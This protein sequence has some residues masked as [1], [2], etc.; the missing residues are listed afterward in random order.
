M[1]AKMREIAEL[2]GVSESTVSRALNNSPLI[3]EKTRK[4]ILEAAR[5]LHYRVSRVDMIGVIEP[6]ITNPLYAEVISAIETRIY[7]AGYGMLLCESEYELSRERDQLDFLLR[8]SSMQGIIMIPIDPQSEHIRQLISQNTPCVFLG[9]ETIPGADQVNVDASMGAY[10]VT[11]YLLELGHKRIGLLQGPNHVAVGRERL[12]G[13]CRALT[14]YQIAFDHKLVSEADIDEAGGALAMK[15]I[16]SDVGG[17]I[18]AVVAISDIMAVGALRYLRE[19]GFRIPEDISLVGCDDIPIG[20]FIQPALTTV[21]QPK[22]ELG[23]LAVKF[24]LKQIEMSQEREKE[25]K[26]IYPFQSTIYHPHI[27]IRESTRKKDE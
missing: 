11:R 9:S 3:S 12:K 25:W 8:H 10:I 15:N 16:L 7:E 5:K 18:S 14:E 1:T 23:T 26:T 27:I 22:R 19:A 13:Y 2:V 21:W 24:L 4:Q 6:K 17:E 20:S